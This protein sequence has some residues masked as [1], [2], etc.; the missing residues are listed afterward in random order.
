MSA[1]RR[2]IVSNSI[3]D[4]DDN[5]AEEVKERMLKIIEMAVE[6]EKLEE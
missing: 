1:E 5:S 6:G 3:E 4:N 2:L